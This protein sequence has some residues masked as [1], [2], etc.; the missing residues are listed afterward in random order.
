MRDLN[1]H[2]DLMLQIHQAIHSYE[3]SLNELIASVEGLTTLI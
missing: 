3:T 1:E 2:I